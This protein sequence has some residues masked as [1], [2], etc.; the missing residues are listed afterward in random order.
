MDKRDEYILA[1]D[2]TITFDTPEGA[3]VTEDE[4]REVAFKAVE[5]YVNEK[6]EEA[7]AAKE[8]SAS[9]SVSSSDVPE[10]DGSLD[11]YLA[12]LNELIGL[13]NVKSEVN[14]L[15]HTLAM[16]K[17]RQEMG[18]PVPEFSNHLVFSGNPGTG[19]TTVAR[20]IAK[21]YKA[22]GILSKGQLVE[23]ER[24]GL[25]AGYVGQT[26]LKTK[27]VIDSA[28]GGVLFI[29]EAYTLAPEGANNDFGQEAIDTILKAMEDH[30]DDFVVIVAGYTDLMARFINSNPG[31]KSRFNKYLDFQDYTPEELEKIFMSFCGK[32]NYVLEDELTKALPGYFENMVNSKD[33]NFANAREVRNLFEKT[34]QK[35]ADRLFSVEDCS[36]EEMQLLKM[37]DFASGGL[38]S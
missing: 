2:I 21:L 28:M 22:L 19:K 13:P 12:E 33:E 11:D 35:Q 18:L 9:K 3:N 31:L 27:E 38:C 37:E 15:I 7:E 36:Q 26:A 14:T 5:K 29:D 24:A 23:T 1:L 16:N 4:I 17:K 34:I 20:I 25:V 32:Y 6:S 8:A 30:R 10:A